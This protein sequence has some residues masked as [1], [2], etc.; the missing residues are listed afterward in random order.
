M[1]TKTAAIKHAT[2]NR[3]VD[4]PGYAETCKAV[5]HDEDQEGA[6][7]RLG[8]GA[9]APA[10]RIAAEHGR[11]EG[12][13]FETHARVRARAADAR[14][15]EEARERAQDRRPDVGRADRAA[16][17]DARVIGR[18]PRAADRRQPPSGPRPRQDNVP[19]DCDH[20]RYDERE[21]DAKDSPLADESPELGIG[22]A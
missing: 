22:E 1:S 16:H 6:H 2:E 12:G 4:R 9:S 15:E 19:G 8:D 3:R 21:G 5:G 14:G 20:G 10:K 18:A 13:H 7:D 11:G 17:L